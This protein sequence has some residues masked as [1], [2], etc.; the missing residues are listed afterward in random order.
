[1]HIYDPAKFK[2]IKPLHAEGHICIDLTDPLTGKVK[3][4][5][6]GENHVF[7]DS[8]FSGNSFD[9]V[10][11]LSAAW[12]CLNDSTAA[13]DTTVPYL[14]GQTVG[15]GIPSA[16]SSGL[17]RGAYNA[18]NQVLAQ[19]SLTGARWKFQYDFTTAQA[20]GVAIG[21]IG[22]TSQYGYGTPSSLNS[23]RHL[24]GF[25]TTDNAN[26]TYTCDGR[27]TYVCSTAGIITKYDLWF[28]TS[29][30]IDV[31]ATVGTTSGT[32]KTVGYAP[33][34]GL[35]YIYCYSSTAGNRK[36]YVFTDASFGTLSTTYS[37]SNLAKNG[38]DPLYIYGTVA[39]WMSSS[40]NNTIYY[41]DFAANVA[42]STLTLSTYNY[43]AYSESSIANG[44]L[45]NCTCPVGSKYVYCE[46]SANTSAKGIIFDLSTG[47]L[48]GYVTGYSTTGYLK[49]LCIH[50]L[51]T[52]KIV[53]NTHNGTLMHKAAIAAYKLPSTVTKTSANGMTATYELEVFW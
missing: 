21:T 11:S 17:Y 37:P 33:A 27:Y 50:P 32:T 25:V 24:S 42:H 3:E 13:I 16:G 40:T 12:L 31:S 23:K 1:M 26:Y 44:V 15:Y 52:E 35:Y 9:W 2:N 22:L 47:T 51:T 46:P 48:A 39:Y 41:A 34:T 45:S 43:A 5:I 6:K 53:C 28:G 10:G 30:T 4:R 38:T 18:A 8:L 19:M 14:M 36:M 20:N 29:T 49:A 7:T